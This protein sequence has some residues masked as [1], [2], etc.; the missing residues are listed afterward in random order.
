MVFIFPLLGAVFSVLTVFIRNIS[1]P[2][3][4]FDGIFY[5]FDYTLLLALC[6][7]A[8]NYFHVRAMKEGTEEMAEMAGI[9]K[10]ERKIQHFL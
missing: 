3:M 4:F 9:K 8:F 5:F 6:Y 2:D 1:G 10:A 7:V